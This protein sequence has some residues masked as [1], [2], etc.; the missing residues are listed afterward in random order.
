MTEEPEPDCRAHRPEGA[1]TL[2][3][4]SK[5]LW[6]VAGTMSLAIGLIGVV[7]PILPTTPFLLLAAACYMRSSRRMYDW[8]MKNRVFGKYLSDY[9]DGRGLSW[10][11]RLATIAFLW[12]VILTSAFFFTDQLWLRVLLIAIAVAVSLH[13]ATI[14]PGARTGRD[15]VA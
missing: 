5:P 7:L 8:M 4:L 15:G 10:K 13:I 12:T 11:V 14:R 2:G 1:D 3:A 9:R 6:F